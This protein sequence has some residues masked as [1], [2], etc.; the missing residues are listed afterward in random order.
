MAD[1]MTQ[2][3]G[4]IAATGSSER[5]G[6]PTPMEFRIGLALAGAISAGAYT[7]GVLDFL[8]EA[9]EQ[10]EAAR[11]QLGVP[12]HRT[13]LKVIAGASAGAITGALGLIAL[14]RGVKPQPLDASEIA[15][16]NRKAGTE[17]N[18]LRCVF[19]SLYKT[20]VEQPRLVAQT[21]GDVD[22]LSL[23]DLEAPAGGGLPSV[24]SLLN[25]RLL[26][27]IKNAALRGPAATDPPRP[28]VA[29][30]MHLYMTVSNLRGIPFKMGFGAGQ[31]GMQT[32]GDRLHYKLK[33]VG[34][35]QCA[36][37]A[38]VN[39]D[40]YI[41]IDTKDLPT[42][43]ND[44]LSPDWDL[45]GT[46]ALAS[47]AFPVGLAS[48]EV[49]TDF[50]QYY[51]RAYPVD[52]EAAF[53]IEPSFPGVAEDYSG[54]Y[55]FLNVDG[56]LINNNP[57]DYA[58]YALLGRPSLRRSPQSDPTK[59]G[60]Q[61]DAALIM[62]APFPEPPVFLP[63]GQPKPELSAVLRALLPTLMTQAR[64]R[65]S[66]LAM[67][68]DPSNYGRYLIAPQR[69]ER[70]GKEAKFKIACGALGGFGGFLDRSFR[71][72][73]YQLGRRNCQEFLRTTFGLPV[74]T[75][76]VDD[77][78]VQH[79]F[80]GT[81]KALPLTRIIPLLGSAAQEVALPHWPRMSEADLGT[82]G[83]RIERRLDKLLPILVKAQT[84]SRRLRLIAAVGLF[85]GKKRLLDA[86][87][88]AV[89]SDL[90]RRDQVEGWALPEGLEFD[91]D[92][93][94]AVLA[95]LVSPRFD[96]RTQAGIAK[97]THFPLAT[98]IAIVGAL[99]Q[100]DGNPRVLCAAWDPD[101]LTLKV[102][103]PAGLQAWPGV[104]TVLRRLSPPSRDDRA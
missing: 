12:A 65:A 3:P 89:L 25:S 31:Y 33:G 95:E 27:E 73:D 70:P 85:F 99:K 61:T 88:F 49:E 44:Q 66:D 100:A 5:A 78:S 59:E 97:S 11:T 96:Y 83:G 84:K 101:L 6:P 15:N 60:Q 28:Y 41:P 104:A 10:W 67:A 63:E 9:L 52:A 40:R 56:G 80:V 81:D 26:D 38:W 64:F 45:Y 21:L 2:Q 18:P 7:A 14:A 74:G 16:S 39:K 94:R 103:E 58:E 93:V 79:R 62:I 91:P 36:D 75:V 57:F 71:A 92:E 102:R 46:V 20:W 53:I 22:F 77:S 43:P 30:E 1:E 8:V 47:A 24:A 37:S 29:E 98:V 19:P 82:L 42:G 4:A 55:K 48:R 76:A 50:M 51:G 90:V 54:V 23:S 69:S 72:H 68:L 34:D 86:V 87:R 35:W 17:Y 32:H 13:G